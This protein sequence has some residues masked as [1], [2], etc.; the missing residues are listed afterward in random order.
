MQLEQLHTFGDPERDPRERVITVV[1]CA[2]VPDDR[3]GLR[4]A[5]DAAAVEWFDLD[6]LPELA[7]DHESILTMAREYI[8]TRLS[9]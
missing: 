4:P 2:V 9:S 6:E 1:Y 8:A 3:M 5:D 7:F